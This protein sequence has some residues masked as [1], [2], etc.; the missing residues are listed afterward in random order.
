MQQ[1]M[2]F[3]CWSAGSLVALLG[4]MTTP[5]MALPQLAV[6]PNAVVPDGAPLPVAR[7]SA[8][9]ACDSLGECGRICP[10][11]GSS[12]IGDFGY[13]TTHDRF[14]VVDV[15]RPDGV[16]W[17][18][19]QSCTVMDY[20]AYAGVSQRGCAVD[21]DNGSV[22]TAGWNDETIWHLDHAF[23]VLGSQFFGEA[24]SGLAVD[25]ANR[26]LYAVTNA[27]C[28]ELIEYAI[29]ADGSVTATGNRRAVPWATFSNGHSSASLEYDDYSGTFMII[30]QDSNSMEYFQLQ[31]GELVS[32]GACRL[33]LYKGWGFG[34]DFATVELRV[35]NARFLACDFPVIAMEPDEMICGGGSLPD[36]V[37]SYD[38]LVSSFVAGG[39]GPIGAVVRNNTDMG[40]KKALWLTVMGRDL[41]VGT[42]VTFPPGESSYY[43]GVVNQGAP[44]PAGDHFAVLNLGDA[45][46]GPVD[47][48]TVIV[49]TVHDPGLVAH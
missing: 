41:P 10:S 3:S 38:A 44:I 25:E 8:N 46:G 17:M 29:E 20:A 47:A 5:A 42:A 31:A 48:R 1:S 33:P 39:G 15:T 6:G 22:Y 12:M 35:A 11:P 16:F 18:D 23:G 27:S 13:D 19:P 14:A 28:D 2:R 9:A 24:Y 37:I 26:L 4:M 43:A 21:N 45:V 40:H 36:F 32:V 34:L 30:N 49:L 7:A